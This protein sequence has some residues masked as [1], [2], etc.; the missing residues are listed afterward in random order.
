[1]SFSG[2]PL[3]EVNEAFGRLTDRSVLGKLAL[4]LA[5]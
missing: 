5:G 1:L 4:D 2:L 3:E